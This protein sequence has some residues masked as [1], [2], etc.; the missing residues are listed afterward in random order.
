MPKCIYC[1]LKGEEYVKENTH[2]SCGS[3][4]SADRDTSQLGRVRTQDEWKCGKEGAMESGI[5]LKNLVHRTGARSQ[6]AVL[7][8]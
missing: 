3:D 6:R 5:F 2:W 1:H 4:L 7:E 8:S